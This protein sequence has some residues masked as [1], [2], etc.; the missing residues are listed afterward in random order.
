MTKSF[1]LFLKQTNPTTWSELLTVPIWHTCMI[2][3]GGSAVLYKNW[4]ENGI[5][6][7]NDLLDVTGELMN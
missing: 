7:I 1:N 4:M 6:L 3:V 2:K 5:V